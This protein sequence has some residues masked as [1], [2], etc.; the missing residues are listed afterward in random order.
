MRLKHPMPG[1]LVGL[2]LLSA[3]VGVN[4]L[5]ANVE[6]VPQ[7]SYT[8]SMEW[9]KETWKADDAHFSGLENQVKTQLSQTKQ[10]LEV[11]KS[12]RRVALANLSKTDAVFRWG[13]ASYLAAR[14]VQTQEE[15]TDVWQSLYPALLR[16]ALP[17]DYQYKPPFS[18]M[19]PKPDS[20]HSY[21]YTRLLFLVAVERYV[22]DTKSRDLFLDLSNRLLQRDPKDKE[23]EFQRIEMLLG[24]P[25]G[26][27]E[28]KI[29]AE[30]SWRKA[31]DYSK[32][33]VNR[34]PKNLAFLAQLAK[35][36]RFQWDGKNSYGEMSIATY[37]KYLALAPPNDPYRKVV[38]GIL[39]DIQKSKEFF[40]KNPSE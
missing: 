22:P 39:A 1:L 40:A 12:Y 5:Q 9:T 2:L 25:W 28:S 26:S 32:K 14:K 30:D 37:R 17:L 20:P 34:N 3:G 36:Y 13:Y 8:D 38:I 23:V 11:V 35:A 31:L 21:R 24:M 27:R 33:A 18:E 6:E 7:L 10:P 19:Y 29:I 4:A 16:P 15:L